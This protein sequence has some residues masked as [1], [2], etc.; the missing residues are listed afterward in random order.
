[1]ISD[2]LG[3]TLVLAGVTASAVSVVLGHHPRVQTHVNQAGAVRIATLALL[4]ASV[5]YLWRS[6]PQLLLPGALLFV[7]MALIARPEG[8]T[9]CA[10][11]ACAFL[12]V[13]LTVPIVETSATGWGAAVAVVAA[14]VL[15]TCLS[16]R[17]S[18]QASAIA[19]AAVWSMFQFL[20][21]ANT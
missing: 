11:F 14:V 15:A 5:L 18:E 9:Q 20:P 10:S 12:L 19:G 13:G 8:P 17:R 2:P 1:M 21:I 16:H 6:V 3:Q 7:P 4:L